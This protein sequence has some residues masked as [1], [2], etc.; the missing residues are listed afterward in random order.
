MGHA[1][2]LERVL[3]VSIGIA[4]SISSARGACAEP[5]RWIPREDA[6]ELWSSVEKFL[7]PELQPDK[8]TSVRSHGTPLRYKFIARVAGDA[9]GALVIVRERETRRSSPLYDVSVA[10]SVDL[11]S[12]T[13]QQLGTFVMWRFVQWARFTDQDQADALFR[14]DSCYE[15]EAET[16]LASFRFDR[17]R[18][19]SRIR[20]WPVDGERILVRADNEPDEDTFTRCLFGVNKER[21][22]ELNALVVWC[23]EFD[24]KTKTIAN[25]N[26]ALYTGAAGTIDKIVPIGTEAQRLKRQLCVANP[27]SNFCRR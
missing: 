4:L 25:E 19:H 22:S 9:D 3:R 24:A 8:P 13:K 23:R 7:E 1:I 14:Y 21:K 16:F 12:S 26:L 20:E 18:R 5:L 27:S 2:T 10:Y 11:S 6:P 15:C 17:I